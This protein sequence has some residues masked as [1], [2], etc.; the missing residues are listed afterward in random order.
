ML[1]ISETSGSERKF[2]VRI[3]L[4]RPSESSVIMRDYKKIVAYTL[5]LLAVLYIHIYYIGSS[6]LI[7]VC[8]Y[9]FSN[10]YFQDFTFNYGL[11]FFLASGLGY[12]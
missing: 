10:N 3:H 7:G 5:E 1:Q 2:S 8:K 9:L 11:N 6:D 12:R 4:A